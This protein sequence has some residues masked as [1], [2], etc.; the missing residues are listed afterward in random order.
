MLKHYKEINLYLQKLTGDKVLAKDLTQETYTK[1]LEVI[2]TVDN[3]SKSYLYKIAKN[4]VID[5]VRRDKLLIQTPFEEDYHSVYKQDS[6]EE[7]LLNESRKTY[8]K[9]CIKN[10]PPQQ[11]KSICFIFL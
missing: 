4:L 10:L 9:E 8:L 5:K 2:K 3:I 7:T 1:F 6:I 11:K